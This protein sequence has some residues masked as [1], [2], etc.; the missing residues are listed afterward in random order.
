MEHISCGSLEHYRIFDDYDLLFDWL[1]QICDGLQYLHQ[2]GIIHRD[3][4]LSNLM[5]TEDRTIKI[6]D[7][8]VSTFRWML[9]LDQNQIIGTPCFMAP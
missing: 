3:I 8:G 4:K 9:P 5:V 7:L 6:I 2:R 1:F